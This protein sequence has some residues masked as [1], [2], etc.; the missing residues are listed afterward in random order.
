MFINLV[1]N[2]LMHMVSVSVY[3]LSNYGNSLPN[4]QDDTRVIIFIK[5]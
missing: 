2:G 5:G 1:I 3:F 4:L